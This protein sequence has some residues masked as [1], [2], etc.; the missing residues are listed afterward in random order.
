MRVVRGLHERSVN[1]RAARV[2]AEPSA[3]RLQPARGRWPDDG[4]FLARPPIKRSSVWVD[5]VTRSLPTLILDGSERF[6]SI[7]FGEDKMPNISGTKGNDTLNGTNNNDTIDGKSGDDSFSAAPAAI[8]WMVA[9]ATTSSM[10][11][12]VTMS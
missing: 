3:A 2:V 11:A 12:S 10:A 4:D 7:I 9:P 8:S 1:L 5:D 6:K